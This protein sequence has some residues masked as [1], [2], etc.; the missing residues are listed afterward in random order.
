MYVYKEGDAVIINK[1][2]VYDLARSWLLWRSPMDD[3]NGMHTIVDR[4]SPDGEIYQLRGCSRWLWH[5]SWLIPDS[6]DN[7]LCGDLESLL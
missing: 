3:Y 4:V 1:P 6:N 5:E 2:S 7:L